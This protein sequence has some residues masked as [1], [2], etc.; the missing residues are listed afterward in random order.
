MG[1]NSDMTA[2]EKVGAAMSLDV[3]R[4]LRT[5]AGDGVRDYAVTASLILVGRSVN[6][7]VRGW[8]AAGVKRA[9]GFWE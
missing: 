2:Q 1:A 9:W 3:C 5:G 7:S 4:V 6:Q 8:V